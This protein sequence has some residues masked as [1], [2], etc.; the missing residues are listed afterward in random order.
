[1][2]SFNLSKLLCCCKIPKRSKQN[3]ESTA[4]DVALQPIPVLAPPTEEDHQERSEKNRQSLIG[5]P[6]TAWA[7]PVRNSSFESSSVIRQHVDD[8]DSDSDQDRAQPTKKSSTAF[9]TVRNKLI[10]TIS[11]S[12]NGDHPS[13]VSVGNSE[14]EIARRAEL[15]R[16]MHQRIQDELKSDE[17]DDHTESK[18]TNSIRCMAS[19]VDVTLPNSGPRDAIEFGVSKSSSRNGHSTQLDSDQV[20]QDTHQDSRVSQQGENRPQRTFSQKSESTNGADDWRQDDVHSRPSPSYPKRHVLASEDGD[21]THSQKSFQLSNG[22]GRLDRILGPDSS[23][24][25]RHASSGDGHS[26]LGV[27]LI[28]QGLRSRDN[29]TLFLD[30]EDELEP[31][32]DTKPTD[33]NTSS[34]KRAEGDHDRERRETPANG[35]PNIPHAPTIIDIPNTVETYSRSN[36]NAKNDRYEISSLSGELPWGPTVTALLNSFTDHTSSGDPS[37]SQPSPMRSQQNLYKL[38][39]KDLDSMELSPFK[40]RSHTS[41]QDQDNANDHN[42]K[43]VNTGVPQI[44]SQSYGNIHNAEFPVKAPQDTTSLAQSES[45]SFLQREAELGSIRRRFSEA[46]ALKKPEKRVVTRFR[47]EFSESSLPPTVHKSFRNKIQLAIPSHLRAK[48]DGIDLRHKEGSS[49]PPKGQNYLLD[50]VERLGGHEREASDRSKGRSNLS[51]RPHMSRLPTEE[52]HKPGLKRR[53]S[54]TDLWQR[55]I[56][57]EVERR[58]SSS[59]HLSTTK[60]SQR[61]QSSNR[62][63]NDLGAARN[64]TS[65]V[66]DTRREVSQL[67]P[68]TDELSSPGNSKWLIE[69]WVAT[70]RPRIGESAGD[71]RLARLAGPPKSWSRFPS[72]N[73]E[74]RNKNATDRDRVHPRDFA[75][76]HM[77]SEGQTRRATD[78]P[79]DEAKQR[80]RTLPRSFSTKFGELVKSK[81]GRIIPSKGIRHRVNQDHFRKHA[82]LSSACMEYPEMGIRPS[83]SGYAELQALGREIRNMKGEPHLHVPDR[84]MS[85]PQSSRSLGDR[86]VAL[87][88]EAIGQRHSKHDD[89]AEVTEYP[90]VPLT[91]SVVRESIVATDVFIT[92]RSRFSND[93]MDGEAKTG[94]EAESNK[95]KDQKA[96]LTV[97]ESIKD[98]PP[99]NSST[100]IKDVGPHTQLST[101]EKGSTQL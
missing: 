85:K 11:H 7:I 26:A 14:E 3:S 30:E 35:N 63:L 49:G 21:F 70:M 19:A 60:P 44:R 5:L 9:D 94:T 27:W 68:T 57:L 10:R 72:H 4:N 34:L 55:A 76:K 37:K 50:P 93:A 62:S 90:T 58:H 78:A 101:P 61:S 87:M 28:A 100:S 6:D 82:A 39:P 86:V 92:P 25:S 95:V 24:N 45:A 66:L 13:H 71:M 47:E 73:R 31:T 18:P 33:Y 74:E 32:E 67:T 17:S 8:D 22:T 51:I 41:S 97:P 29:S 53:E 36:F 1:M 91:P 99:S 15:K 84:E 46:L 20:D 40:W 38:D 75:V 89:A 69:R 42:S 88:H 98:A 79:L 2:P 56:R 77:T 59:I 54:A 48:S 65:S 96:Q 83:E 43:S 81:M 16:I 12:N 23:F 52:Y 64:S 80:A